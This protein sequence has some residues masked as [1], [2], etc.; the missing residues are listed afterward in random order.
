MG[1]L[2]MH[3]KRK[4]RQDYKSRETTYVTDKKGKY[5]PSSFLRRHDTSTL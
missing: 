5:E 4:S 3:W 2:G 1:V